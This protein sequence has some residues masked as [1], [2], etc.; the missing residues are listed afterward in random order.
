[1]AWTGGVV[2]VFERA[3]ALGILGREVEDATEELGAILRASL[4]SL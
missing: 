2:L 1:M 3:F 4:A